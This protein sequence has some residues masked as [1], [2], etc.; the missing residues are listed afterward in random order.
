LLLSRQFSHDTVFRLSLQKLL[1][2]EKMS[3]ARGSLMSGGSRRTK[4]KFFSALRATFVIAAFLFTFIFYGHQ[5]GSSDI[6]GSSDHFGQRH[7]LQVA[8]ENV[9][10]FDSSNK[11]GNDTQS[12]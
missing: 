4:A 5:S 6:A 12:R 9:S 11:T 8:N 7:L 2:V 10:D 3:L 1:K